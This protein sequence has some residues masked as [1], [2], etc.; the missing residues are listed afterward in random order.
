MVGKRMFTLDHFLQGYQRKE[1]GSRAAEQDV[2]L[3]YPLLRVLAE[4]T[5]TMALLELAA[6]SG[7]SVADA[8]QAAAA[9]GSRSFVAVTPDPDR[10]GNDLVALTPSGRK[11]VGAS[12]R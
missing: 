4:G 10:R 7:L 8:Q 9:L 11:L 2:A 5:G 12:A 3:L 6:K 1:R